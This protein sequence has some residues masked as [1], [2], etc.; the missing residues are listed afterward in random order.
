MRTAQFS[1]VTIVPTIPVTIV[2]GG[3]SGAPSTPVGVPLQNRFSPLEAP[4]A[5]RRLVLIGGGGSSQFASWREPT[6]EVLDEPVSARCCWRVRSRT[7]R[8]C[9]AG[10]EEVVPDTSEECVV[11]VGF[12]R[13]VSLRMALSLLDDVDLTVVFRQRA[14][15]VRTVHHFLRS[16]FRNAMKLALEEATWGNH[17]M[18][19]VRQERGWKL[20]TLLP[21]MWL[22]RPPGGGLISKEKLVGR[23]QM[24]ARGE[25]IP[26]LRASATRDEQAARARHRKCHCGDDVERR[27]MRAERLVE[28]GELSSARQALE[29]AV[30][31]PGDQTTLDKLQDERRRPQ[32]PREPLPPDMITF[33]PEIE[34][35]LDEKMFGKNLRSS[36]IGVAGGPSGMT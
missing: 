2:Q 3:R 24:F 27:V 28:L 9:I 29:G 12:P 26:L 33:H 34:F 31:A 1:Q 4:R 19:T 17:R 8:V 23:F 20:F 16:S 32:Q 30:L 6:P 25:W 36:K 11:D 22:H 7:R 10:A 14:A 15:V 35:Q 21:R 5:S 18:D 13:N